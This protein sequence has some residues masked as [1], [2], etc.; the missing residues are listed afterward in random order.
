MRSLRK[1]GNMSIKQQLQALREEY[2][3]ASKERQKE[4]L[5]EAK[6]LKENL[7]Y[8]CG[9][10]KY[11]DPINPF[12]SPEC[13]KKWGDKNYLVGTRDGK[14]KPTIEQMQKRLLE[15]AKEKLLSKP[16]QKV[17]L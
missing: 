17:L 13:H 4:I 2:K 9:D 8:E 6:K 1:D 14:K 10:R 7:C 11:K 16:G 5:D 15:M 12:C 3:N